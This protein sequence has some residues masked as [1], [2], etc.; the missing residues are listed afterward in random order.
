MRRFRILITPIPVDIYIGEHFRIGSFV[1]VCYLNLFG[2]VL[3]ARG[4]NN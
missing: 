1:G 3:I 4:W 2:R